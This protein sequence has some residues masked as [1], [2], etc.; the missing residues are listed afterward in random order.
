MGFVIDRFE[1]EYAICENDSGET[2]LIARDTLPEDAR[3]G[4]ILRKKEEGG[5]AADPVE[6]EQHLEE[7]TCRLCDLFSRE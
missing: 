4:D 5:Y 2:E 7:V 6:K 1:G 3:E